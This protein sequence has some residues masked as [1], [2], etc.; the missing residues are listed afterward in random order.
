MA[1]CLPDVKSHEV[2]D[3]RTIKAE[4]K[5]GIGFIKE[6]F[7]S[8]IKYSEVDEANKHLKITIDS[9]AKANTATMNI[10]VHVDGDD[11]K[12]S[13]K[14]TVDA[15]MAGRL[16]SIGQR[17]ISKVSDRVIEQSFECMMSKLA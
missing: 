4:M 11:S 17:Y 10:D 8:T 1:E 16:A 15:V 9:R 5:V 12:A 14:W 7:D 6:V 13:L 2:V 3:D